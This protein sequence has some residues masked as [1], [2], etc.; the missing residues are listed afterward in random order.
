MRLLQ[1][2]LEKFHRAMKW[3]WGSSKAS[4]RAAF[5]GLRQRKEIQEV[6]ECLL[7]IFSALLWADDQN[8]KP[9]PACQYSAVAW[10]WVSSEF[11]AQ[12]ILWLTGDGLGIGSSHPNPSLGSKPPGSTERAGI[13]THTHCG[14]LFLLI[15]HGLDKIGAALIW[16]QPGAT[17]IPMGTL[18]KVTLGRNSVCG[19]WSLVIL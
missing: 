4:L 5:P 10:D 8:T 14:T 2:Y 3:K 7:T 13:T 15:F 9:S 17:V 18:R 6:R 11:P 12:Q 1:T 16:I 19:Y